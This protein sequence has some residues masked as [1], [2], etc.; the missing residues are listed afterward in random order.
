MTVTTPAVAG[1]LPAIR[2][3]QVLGLSLLLALSAHVS[4]PFWPVPMTMQTLAVLMIAGLAGPWRASGAM[5]TYLAEGALGLPVFAGTPARGL[6]LAYLAGPTGGYLAGMLV[7][8]AVVGWLARR[9]AFR[10]AALLGAMTLGSLLV[11]ALGATWLAAFVGP[12]KAVALGV[13]PFLAG[14]AVKTALATA[15]VLAARQMR[16]T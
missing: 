1:R 9:A 3:A 12:A 16:G 15:A 2:A 5:L 11:Y 10:P 7:A 14:D 4:V 6:G 13:Q 8:A